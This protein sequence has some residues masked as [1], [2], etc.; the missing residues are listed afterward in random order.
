MTSTGT[1]ALFPGL[2]PIISLI[3]TLQD[4]SYNRLYFPEEEAEGQR[5]SVTHSGSHSLP[6]WALHS[7][8][9]EEL[10]SIQHLPWSRQGAKCL[11]NLQSFHSSLNS[12]RSA[13]LPRVTHEELKVYT[14]V[15]PPSR[16]VAD[17][18]F[19]RGSTGPQPCGL[20]TTLASSRHP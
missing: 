14:I 12:M 19:E 2:L 17:L 5:G 15:L 8:K 1:Q 10:G 3:T 4:T 13:P 7:G 6:G 18:E 16:Q 20:S 11:L 9:G